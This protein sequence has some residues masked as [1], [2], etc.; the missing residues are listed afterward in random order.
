MK[1]V[2]AEA[3]IIGMM[4]AILGVIVGLVVSWGIVVIAQL[5]GGWNVPYV[6]PG[7]YLLLAVAVSVFVTILASIYPARVAAKIDI[8]KAVQ[9]E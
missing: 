7:N 1:M 5:V 4:G 9:Y 8:V 2:I 3:M 6:F